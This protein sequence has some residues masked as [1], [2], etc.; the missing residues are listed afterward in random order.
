MM[1]KI[2]LPGFRL[3][4]TRVEEALPAE[5]AAMGCGRSLTEVW[6]EV[7]RPRQKKNEKL[8]SRRRDGR[9]IVA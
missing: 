3:R 8:D 2:A 9:P 7:V 6:G 4:G 1:H 5:F